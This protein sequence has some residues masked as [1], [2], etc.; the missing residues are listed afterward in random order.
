MRLEARINV[1]AVNGPCPGVTHR[2]L[3]VSAGAPLPG[4]GF[5][6]HLGFAGARQGAQETAFDL[7]D[8]AAS[9]ALEIAASA[10]AIKNVFLEGNR[11]GKR[12]TNVAIPYPQ[13]PLP[14]RILGSTQGE[15]GLQGK[16]SQVILPQD[17]ALH[18]SKQRT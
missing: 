15:P 4:T 13:Q 7:P 1:D 8:R 6:D 17:A 14:Q 9:V 3:K 11:D 12:G 2:A 10:P 16:I 18:P 5:D